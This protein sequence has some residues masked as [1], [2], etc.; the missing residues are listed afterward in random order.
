MTLTD[1]KRPQAIAVF[2]KYLVYQDL[3]GVSVSQGTLC[4]MTP[5]ILGISLSLE[6]ERG[7]NPRVWDAGPEQMGGGTR[8]D[9]L[10]DRATIR[11]MRHHIR[12]LGHLVSE[13]TDSRAPF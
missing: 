13:S 3:Y 10:G 4:L 11:H 2:C 8:S 6:D 12:A 7:C 5:H 1:I 9:W